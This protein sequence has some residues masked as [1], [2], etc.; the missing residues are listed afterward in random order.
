MDIA[1]KNSLLK[2]LTHI[3]KIIFLLFQKSEFLVLRSIKIRLTV[4][5]IIIWRKE[6]DL[7][8]REITWWLIIII[9]AFFVGAATNYMMKLWKNLLGGT[10]TLRKVF[11]I[12]SKLLV[13]FSNPKSMNMQSVLP[14]SKRCCWIPVKNMKLLNHIK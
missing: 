1:W 2:Y 13:S 3:K 6:W 7:N 14:L 10:G 8:L 9:G 4:I 12:S 5:T 11:V